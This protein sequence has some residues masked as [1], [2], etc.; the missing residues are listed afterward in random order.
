MQ[1]VTDTLEG[2]YDAIASATLLPGRS[3]VKDERGVDSSAGDLTVEFA[4]TEQDALLEALLCGEW[5][6]T[7]TYPAPYTMST[8]WFP[9]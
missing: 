6:K 3:P 4:V 8:T 1:R 9:K 5:T 7:L 2:A